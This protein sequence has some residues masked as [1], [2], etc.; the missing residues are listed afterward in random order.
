M[1]LNKKKIIFIIG[2]GVL[3]L[4]LLLLVTYRTP[5]QKVT[6][7][8]VKNGYTHENDSALYSKQISNLNYNQ[9]EEQVKEG[10]SSLYEENYFDTKQYEFIK[11][12]M[13]YSDGIQ[14]NFTPQYD[15]KNSILSYTYRVTIMDKSSVIFEGS[16]NSDF[17]SLVCENS[18]TYHFDIEGNENVF[19]DKIKIEVKKFYEE[20]INLIKDANLVYRMMDENN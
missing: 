15:Y 9:Y 3:F 8:L 4:F 18:Y 1:K 5:T 7:L 12:K 2:G 19:C 10:N 11:V 17:D 13:E 16:Y 14:T 6:K 20:M